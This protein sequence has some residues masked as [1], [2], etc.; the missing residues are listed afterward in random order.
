M[1]KLNA[2]SKNEKV[3]NQ[4]NEEI[5]YNFEVQ[6]GFVELDIISLDEKTLNRPRV[7]KSFLNETEPG[8]PR[9]RVS[10]R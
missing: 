6:N 10:H 2:Q 5:D 1:K 4:L 8:T 7:N 3:T 9:S